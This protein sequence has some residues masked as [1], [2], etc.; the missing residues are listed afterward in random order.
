[1]NPA[2]DNTGQLAAVSDSQQESKAIRTE[3]GTSERYVRTK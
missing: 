1:M 3:D 2:S